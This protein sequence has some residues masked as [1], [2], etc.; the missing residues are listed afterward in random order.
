[1]HRS[2]CIVFVSFGTRIAGNGPSS[3]TNAS[4]LEIPTC[5]FEHGL[6]CLLTGCEGNAWESTVAL[7][8][9]CGNI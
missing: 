7:S 8:I 4:Y 3:S 2:V 6:Y 1:M 5:R 9:H